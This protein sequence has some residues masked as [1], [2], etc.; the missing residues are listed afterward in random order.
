MK[1]LVLFGAGKIGRSF[2]GQLFSMSGYEVVFIDV[3]EPVI[4]EL[5]QRNEY[6]VIIKSAHPDEVIKV[7]NVRGVWAKD[8]TQVAE[9]LSDCDI[10]AI[11]VGQKGLPHVIALIAKG[12]ILR[13]K[14]FGEKPLDIILAE[15]MRNAGMYVK[16]ILKD[17]LDE[18]FPIDELVGL[19]ETSIGKMVP[20]MPLEEQEKDL[21]LVYAEPYNTLILDKKAFIN[22]IP[23]VNGLVPKENI[24]AW[25]DRKSYI[26]NFGHAVAAYA[27]FLTDPSVTYLSDILCNSEVKNFTRNAMLQSAKILMRKYPGEFSMSDL[28]K[29][30]DDLLYRFENR[31][32]GD[33]VFRV[34]CDLKRKLH[35]NDRILSPLM[36]G[37]QFKAPVSKI[38]QTFAYGLCFRAMDENRNMF[39]GDVEFSNTLHDKGLSFVLTNTCGLNP[40]DDRKLINKIITLG[41]KVSPIKIARGQVFS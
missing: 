22:P 35:R 12:L 40:V 16:D 25:V 18:A 10:A 15:N 4:R 37:I 29:H 1:K 38:L 14:K 23:E 7:Q 31:A 27:G 5:N 13:Q 9:E 2:I 34:G 19:I 30:I 11:S 21:L 32:L 41:L 8:E 33:T 3:F 20:I 28:T 24:N 36:D 39:P 26:H 6:N 17:A